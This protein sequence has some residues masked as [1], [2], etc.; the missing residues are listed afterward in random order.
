MKKIISSEQFMDK[1]ASFFADIAHVLSTKVGIRLSSV[2]MP[3]NVACYQVRGTKRHLM[4]RL[5]LIPLS[6]GRMLARL[7]WLDCRG[8][9]HVCCY[10]NESFECLMMASDG[11]WKKQKKSAE[12]LCLQGLEPLVA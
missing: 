11:R 10:I 4:L 5:V 8:I 6:T 3:Q 9:D 7:S 12:L 1:S 2:S